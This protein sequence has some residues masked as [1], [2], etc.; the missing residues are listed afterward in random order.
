MPIYDYSFKVWIEAEDLDTAEE[1]IREI[2]L[3][4]YKQ[5]VIHDYDGPL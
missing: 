3:K 4:L 1:E 2:F 5:K